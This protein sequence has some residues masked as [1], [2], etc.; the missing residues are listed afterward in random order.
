MRRGF[1]GVTLAATTL[2]AAACSE[3]PTSPSAPPQVTLPQRVELVR[4]QSV[5]VPGTPLQLTL[6]MAPLWL[7]PSCP[8]GRDT[9]HCGPEGPGVYLDA[10]VPGRRESFDLMRDTRPAR[11]FDRY[12]IR[13]EAISPEPPLYASS[14]DS[15]Y[16][17]RLL[18]TAATTVP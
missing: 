4:G 15:N 13:L 10:Q 11:S 3:R 8:V 6:R 1:A 9:I 2:I 17:A 18:V 7:V 16:T 12:E 14:A 5:T